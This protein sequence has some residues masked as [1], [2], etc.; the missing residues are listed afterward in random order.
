MLRLYV[1][2]VVLMLTGCQNDDP[3]TTPA[4]P[5][6]ETS[7]LPL[8][9]P[10]DAA[11]YY[12]RAQRYEDDGDYV[13]ADADYTR[14][15]QLDSANADYAYAMASI[16]MDQERYD[17]AARVTQKLATDNDPR[18]ALLLAE[19]QYAQGD[20]EDA[21]TT[22][23]LLTTAEL[24]QQADAYYLVG[25]AQAALGD[26][27]AALTT[28]KQIDLVDRQ[29]L[30]GNYRAGQL[31]LEQN[32]PREAYREF[33]IVVNNDPANVSAH[34]LRGYASELMGQTAQAV[35]D[36]EAVLRMEPTFSEAR[37]ALDRVSR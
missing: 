31:L 32:R 27:A 37:E 9:N 13:R 22:A 11:A 12:E 8:A 15:Y 21:I 23:R 5:A 19:V 29:H 25:E 1:L 6:A 35:R 4:P 7:D 17:D 10:G 16:W 26:T 33:N 3:T 20:Y 28:Y 14:A 34:Y 2:V 36:Y 18:H 30:R 24:P